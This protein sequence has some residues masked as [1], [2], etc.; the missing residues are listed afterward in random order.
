MEITV[1]E[2]NELVLNAY[3]KGKRECRESEVKGEILTYRGK[4]CYDTT[5]IV[6]AIMKRMGE[7]ETSI[8]SPK[9][10]IIWELKDII[11]DEFLKPLCAPKCVSTKR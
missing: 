2:L 8:D 3:E 5:D 6:I 1:N 9:N 4:H 7:E 10:E 11:H